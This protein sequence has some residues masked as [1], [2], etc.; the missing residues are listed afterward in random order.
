MRPSQGQRGAAER[1]A[2]IVN[3]S[4]DAII[5]KT[6]DG[7]I[8]SWNDGARKLF[9]YEATESIGK[10]MLMLIPEDRRD[11][12]RSILERIARGERVPAF[13]TVR[14]RKDGTQVHVS[15]SIS[16]V[17]DASGAIVGA[18]KIAR[19]ITH[20]RARE[21]EIARLSRLY[22]A[23]GQVNKTIARVRSRGELFQ[24]VCRALVENGG[25]LMSWIGAH[26][27]DS[28]LIVPV[29]V[30]GD[31]TGYL[32]RVKVYSDDRPEGR[33]PTGTAFR[34]NRSYICNDMTGEG[35]TL[36][37][38]REFM[39]RGV[40]SSAA[41]PFQLA[42]APF[43]VLTVHAAEK[44][45]FQDKELMLLEE[46]AGDISFALETIVNEEGLRRAQAQL[47]ESE[48]RFRQIAG[49]ITEV[50]W[51]ADPA[52]DR[53]LYVS[54]AYQKIWGLSP[55]GLYKSCGAWLEAVHPDDRARVGSATGFAGP[56]QEHD[57]TY[58]ILR[59]DGEVRWIRERRFPVQDAGGAV[60]R[61]VGTAEDVTT[62]RTYLEQ[63]SEQAALLD[64]AHEA[65]YVR[66]MDN[67][68]VYWNKGAETTFGWL[69]DEVLGLRL[70]ELTKTDPAAF[71]AASAKVL[72]ENIWEGE[73]SCQAK[74]G[75]KLQ[76]LA[77]WT[78][79]RDDK[80]IPKSI[81]AISTDIT[82]KKQLESQFLRA[83]RLESIGTL[84]GGISHDLNNLLSPI[85][86]GTGLLREL[87]ASPDKLD[88]IQN[89]ELSAKRGADLVG[90]VLSFARGLVGSKVA[91]NA[92]YT[93]RE[94]KALI[95]GTFPKNIT[96]ETRIAS[97][98]WLINADPTQ[99]NQVLMNL[100]VNARDAMPEGGQLKITASNV[101]IDQ[102]FAAT[103]GGSQLGRHVLVQVADNGCGIPQ[104]IVDRIFEP[105]FTTKGAGIGTGL[106]LSTV[107]GIV[108]SHGGFVRVE[109]AVGRGTTFSV[110]LP[111]SEESASSSASASGEAE[112]PRG[113]GELIMVVDDEEPVLTVTRRTLE[114]FGYQVVT[115]NQG[116]HAMSVYVMHRDRV[117]AVLTDMMMPVMDGTALIT[118]LNHINPK[119]RIIATSGRANA[120]AG[121]AHGFRRFLAKPFSVGS[122]LS[123]LKSVL[124]EP[125]E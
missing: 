84:A 47:S 43:G 106:G 97:D 62:Q 44:D 66:D 98:L 69:A 5:G 77:H 13:E 65:I 78:L 23:L 73:F 38:H 121:S 112:M 11:E 118:A 96:L 93:V 114:A 101:T 17:H 67:H 89:I 61:V 56:G 40:F 102:Q 24:A 39:Q 103:N 60:L 26:D 20:Q 110:Y 54:P 53:F 111:A 64:A 45:F 109:S 51:I 120:A 119:L 76:V 52:T 59:P 15:V 90:Q 55:G 123:T 125:G 94:V 74:D 92:G 6:L 7:I 48:E 63:I 95:D 25:F 27:P 12:E 30:R 34:E 87:E 41:I 2:A 57:E 80:G 83:Q 3:A 46:A 42:G 108:R 105:F 16:P 91:L 50:F 113:N 37:W 9:G 29:A 58:R 35:A 14:N 32:D 82:E 70:E 68:I 81:L 21:R 1:L 4:D 99:L 124:A 88:I 79:V 28:K 22:A 49:N 104:E 122:L 10:P 116:A 117:A 72:A 19:D 115:A 86:M 36:Q 107:L 75:R 100:C 71:S 85:I 8:I 31:K 18:S 33:G